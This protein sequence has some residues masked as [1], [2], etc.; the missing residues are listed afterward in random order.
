MNRT[1]R[2]LGAMAAVLVFQAPAA[3][4]Y[5]W[6]LAPTSSQPMRWFRDTVEVRVSTVEP[7]ELPWFKMRDRVEQ[8]FATWA[9]VPDCRVPR[10]EVVGTTKAQTITTPQ[11]LD[12]EPDNVVVFIKSAN[13]W[14]ALPGALPGTI[15]LTFISHV[16]STGEII[17][18]DIAFN[19]AAFKFTVDDEAE[20]G[21]DLLSAITH[22]SGHF[23]GLG[24]SDDPEASMYADYGTKGSDRLAARTLAPDDIEGVCAL[25]EGA[26]WEPQGGDGTEEQPIVS[27][28]AAQGCAGGS[29]AESMPW[30][31]GAL[32]LLVLAR[33]RMAAAVGLRQGGT[34]TLAPATHSGRP[35]VSPR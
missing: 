23:L 15:A 21:V 2:L 30:W 14:A 22:E 34:R 16:P 8:A 26:P 13:K 27:A 4:A 19:D 31:L 17:D 28:P 10:I 12:D 3:L 5:D 35:H 7:A 33:R 32:V 29:P 9:E 1:H 11:S 25:Y 18:A 24:H 20:L 6:F